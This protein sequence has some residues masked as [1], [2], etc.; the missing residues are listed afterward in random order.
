M[1]AA[2]GAVLAADYGG[3][4]PVIFD[5]AFSFSDSSRVQ[6]FQRMLDLAVARGL[7]IVIL[8]TYPSD[9]AGLGAS[10]VIFPAKFA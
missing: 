8:T 4:L 7:Q 3:T 2:D 9:C 1:G 10:E 5:D 6:D